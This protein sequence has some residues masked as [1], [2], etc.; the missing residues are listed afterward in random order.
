MCLLCHNLVTEVP[1]GWIIPAFSGCYNIN[2]KVKA[3]LSKLEIWDPRLNRKN[4]DSFTVVPNF[5]NMV[6]EGIQEEITEE[7]R[8]KIYLRD[9]PQQLE[10]YFRLIV[11]LRNPFV[12]IAQIE[13]N[14]VSFPSKYIDSFVGL[15]TDGSSN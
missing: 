7:L 9:L 5:V 11:W 6:K 3:L 12:N 15:G 10:K 13:E 14:E 1:S 2:E 4:S 8:K